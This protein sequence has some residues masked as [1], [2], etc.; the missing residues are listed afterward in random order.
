[1]KNSTILGLRCLLSAL[2]LS[3]AHYT[4]AQNWSLLG[5]SGIDP[6][7]HFIGTIDNKPLH[8]RV[9]NLRA[10]SIDPSKS[11]TFLGGLSNGAASTGQSNSAFGHNALSANTTGNNNTAMGRDALRLNTTGGDNTALGTA[12][13]AKNTTGIWNTAVGNGALFNSTISIAN[14][15]VG[16]L[17]LTANTTGSANTGIGEDALRRN[18]TGAGNSALG[19]N[20]LNFNTSGSNNTGLGRST[21]IVNF[22]NATAIGYAATANASNKIRLGNA[23][24][25]SLE[26]QVNLTVTSDRRFK[27]DL[28]EDVSGLDFIMRLRPVTYHYD[29]HALH[30]FYGVPDRVRADA[31]K[32]IEGQKAAEKEL[33]ELDANARDA[34]KIRYTGFIAQEVEEAATE[35]GYD[36]SGVYK[37][38]NEQDNYGLRYAEFTVPLVKAVQEQQFILEKQARQ[39]AELQTLI[40]ALLTEPSLDRSLANKANPVELIVSPNPSAGIISLGFQLTR[41]TEVRVSVL[42]AQGKVVYSQLLG[43]CDVGM[44]RHILD[45]QKLPNGTYCINSVLD[46][47]SISKQVIINH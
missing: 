44:N 32:G 33:A 15:A 19:E 41:E 23:G 12:S 4:F 45:L 42:D 35:V 21:S 40:Q 14:T 24:L 5:N 11:N 25:T 18:I 13:L 17:A 2:A 28:R 9:N 43:L 47:Q 26:S 22:N 20:A 3:F 36:F 1:M 38:Q 6:T 34:E 46:G 29:I 39:I 16:D 27:K 7:I 37:P 30:D 31:S 8:F 10:G